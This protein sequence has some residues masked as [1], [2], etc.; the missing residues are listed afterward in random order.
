[1]KGASKRV[2]AVGAMRAYR[3]LHKP[4]TSNNADCCKRRYGRGYRSGVSCG[5]THNPAY[6]LIEKSAPTHPGD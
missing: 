1:M 6:G 4:P 3:K 5:P 2:Q